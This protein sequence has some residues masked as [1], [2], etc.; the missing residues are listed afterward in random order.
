MNKGF[1]IEIQKDLTDKEN[2]AAIK[3]IDYWVADVMEHGCSWKHRTRGG[4]SSYYRRGIY[5]QPVWD[6]DTGESSSTLVFRRHSHNRRI[7]AV[8][9][10]DTLAAARHDGCICPIHRGGQKVKYKIRPE[11]EVYYE[12]G[13]IKG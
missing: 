2:K 3:F 9:R 8:I 11:T 10:I 12:V 6:P 4:H 7:F 1:R 5:G 13:D